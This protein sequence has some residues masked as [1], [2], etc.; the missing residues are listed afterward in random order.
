MLK[1]KTNYADTTND[2]STYQALKL[3]WELNN[4]DLN[5]KNGGN[6]NDNNEGVVLNKNFIKV[7]LQRETELEN[8]VAELEEKLNHKDNSVL[9]FNDPN[10]LREHLLRKLAACMSVSLTSDRSYDYGIG[11]LSNEPRFFT[12]TYEVSI[13]TVLSE[14]EFSLLRELADSMRSSWDDLGLSNKVSAFV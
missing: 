1:I 8:K 11:S 2:N 4:K 12:P 10:D 3:W 5:Y 13:S 9:T 14:P 7:H 6:M